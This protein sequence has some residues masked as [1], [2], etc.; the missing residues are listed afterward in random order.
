MKTKLFIFDMGEV[1][2]L[3]G[4]NLPEIARYLSI[5]EERLRKDYDKYDYPMMEG[6][7]DTS[8]YMEHLESEFGVKTEGNI[9]SR[10]YSPYTNTAILPV[11]KLIKDK[12]V[13]LVVGSNTFQ[14][15]VDVIKTLPERPLDYFDKLYFSHDMHLTKPSLSFFNYILEREKVNGDDTYFVDDR[16]ENTAAA[17]SLGI[18]TFLYSRESNDALMEDVKRILEE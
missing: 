11:L 9:F 8:L 12:G 7:M 5:D 15:H 18:K 10:V 13:R 16:E 2:V 4:M 1:L 3:D 14:P 6:Y 17:F